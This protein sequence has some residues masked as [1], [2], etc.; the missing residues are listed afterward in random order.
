MDP[1]M[2]RRAAWWCSPAEYCLHR[3]FGVRRCSL[4]L[5]SG[6]GLLDMRACRWD[7][8]L[9]EAVGAAPEGLSE[10][11]DAPVTG[12]SG[13]HSSRWPGLARVPWFPAASDAACSSL[14]SG[15]Q[16]AGTVAAMIGTSGAMRVVLPSCPSPVP[17]GLWCYR[18]DRRRLLL[19]GV[20]GNAGNLRR[21]MADSLA[22]GLSALQADAAILGRGPG[23]HGLTVLPFF[24]GERSTGWNPHARAAITGMSLSTTPLD[25]L[26]AGMEAVAYRLA[27]IFDLLRQVTPEPTRIVAS[28]GALVRSRAWTQILADVLE[29]PVTRSLAAEASSRGAALLALEGLG[30]KVEPSPEFGETVG[31]R[32]EHA[33]AHRSARA[34]QEK[35]RDLLSNL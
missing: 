9:L 12:L 35:L 21:W 32:Q 15:C 34:R 5:A 29:R 23:V 8:Q 2:F 6:T 31:P 28:G 10:L 1:G 11:S 26:Q 25:I 4:S 30:R 13:P 7:P 14:G 17:Q 16:A 3:L 20:V 33:A 22:L 27:A 19:G 24:T 18:L